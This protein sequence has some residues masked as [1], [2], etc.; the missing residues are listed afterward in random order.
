MTTDE[1]IK[2]AIRAF[3]KKWEY[4]TLYYSDDLYGHEKDA[5]EV[6][7]YVEELEDIGRKAFLEKY[8]NK[9]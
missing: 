5:N 3:D 7:T 9:G 4:E 6:W 2:L 8:I 1:I